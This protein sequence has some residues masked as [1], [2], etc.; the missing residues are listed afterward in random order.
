MKITSLV[1]LL[2]F[3]CLSA[4]HAQNEATKHYNIDQHKV[5]LEGY[6]P[7]SYFTEQKPQKGN[8]TFDYTYKGVTY[9]FKN[10]NNKQAFIKNPTKYEPA[11]GGW[12]AL[13]IAKNGEKVAVDPLSYKIS[14]GRL[15]LFYKTA[16]YSALNNWNK[17]KTP[18]SELLNKGD[19]YWKNIIQQ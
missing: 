12:C 8:K 6:D 13:A 14:D 2:V 4:L 18:E 16:F 1:L 17:D 5:A 7:V 11:Y 3:S 9:Y 19:Q 10:D 15:L